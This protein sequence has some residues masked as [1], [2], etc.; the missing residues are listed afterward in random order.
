MSEP[1]RIVFMGTADLAA[2]VLRRLSGD[3]RWTV[4]LAVSQP[5]KPKG[6]DLTLQPTPVKSAALELG[7]PVDQPLKARLP[8]FL[9]RLR[10]LEPALIVVAAYGQLLPQALLDIPRHGCLNVHTSLL[11]LYR[12]AAP[13]QWAI[14]DG[15]H[16]TGVTL[17]RMDAGLDT[18]P[19]V[20]T[21][22]TPITDADTGQTLHD[23]LA[24]LGGELLVATLP[25]YVAGRRIPVPQPSEGVTLARKIT[26]ED[27]RI[28]W[29]RPA[30]ETWR[31]TRAFS[32][33]PGAW[34]EIPAS[35]KPRLLKVHKVRPVEGSG[36]PGTV[37][38]S[39]K[40]RLVVACG[41]GALELEEVQPE[42][43]RRMTSA[44]FLAAQRP[45]RLS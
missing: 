3:P 39:E 18:G 27:G 43:G 22:D 13:I 20:A 40:G 11:P 16:E 4:V 24:E 26:R 21:V 37:L 36:V 45:E 25:D 9:D 34:C 8:D 23:R 6:R 2:T 41:E 31:R 30:V 5:D 29:E 44:Q 1:L 35:P 19:V 10:A 42:A 32:P 7:I 28:V 12:G 15:R 33:W 14:A 38:P 17:M